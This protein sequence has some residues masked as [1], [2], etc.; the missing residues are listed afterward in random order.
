MRITI[1]KQ[2]V[3]PESALGRLIVAILRGELDE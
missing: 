3:D 2:A 1:D